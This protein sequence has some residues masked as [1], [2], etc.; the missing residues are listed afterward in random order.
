[1]PRASIVRSDSPVLLSVFVRP[2]AGGRD[3]VGRHVVHSVEA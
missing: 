2:R 1:M 3:V